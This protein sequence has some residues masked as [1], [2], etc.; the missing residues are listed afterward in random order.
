MLSKCQISD[1]HENEKPVACS[2]K[3]LEQV[4]QSLGQ[5]LDTAD[6]LQMVR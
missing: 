4:M 2:D 3:V 1:I 6:L 5:R